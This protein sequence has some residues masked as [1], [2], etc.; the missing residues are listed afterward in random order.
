[1]AREKKK[2]TDHG[3]LAR[4]NKRRFL[5]FQ[6]EYDWALEFLPGALNSTVTRDSVVDV[7]PLVLTQRLIAKRAD[8][9][10]ESGKK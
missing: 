6:K 4:A 7:I 3:A 2:R 10:R 5:A 9:F 8:E 1:M